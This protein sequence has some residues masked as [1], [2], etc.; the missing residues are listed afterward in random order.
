M[1]G[2]CGSRPI[3]R[4]RGLS[5]IGSPRGPGMMRPSRRAWNHS[6]SSQPSGSPRPGARSA[7]RRDG[8]FLRRNQ[9]R[10]HPT[11]HPRP[12]RPDARR[13]LP[14]RHGPRGRTMPDR[15]V[16]AVH[17]RPGRQP[18]R[19]H[20]GRARARLERAARTEPRRHLRLRS[21]QGAADST[22]GP[23]DRHGVLAAVLSRRHRPAAESR[24]DPRVP[25]R[26]CP[27]QA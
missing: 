26:S 21:T 20:S 27:R 10:R 22:F 24:R 17:D 8:R 3:R 14:R 19:L 23:G 12:Q 1:K 11:G 18:T 16:G 6:A 4:N 5:A 7:A 9:A 25:G 15:G 13:G 2:A